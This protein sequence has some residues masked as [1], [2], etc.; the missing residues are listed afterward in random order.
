MN[1]SR[2]Q[3]RILEQPEKGQRID[4]RI[5]GFGQ[6]IGLAQAEIAD[7]DT[8]KRLCAKLPAECAA[9]TSGKN[10]TL[11]QASNMIRALLAVEA[12]A[13]PERVGFPLTIV[14]IPK[15]GVGW[16]S[17]YETEIPAIPAL[18]KTQ[19]SKGK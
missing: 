9:F 14:T 10:L 19:C 11:E 5:A 4:Y 18:P 15:S 6:H 7:S 17:T 13:N 3:V 8:H 2:G 16:V 12:E 1:E